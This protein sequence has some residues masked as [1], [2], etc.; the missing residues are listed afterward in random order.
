MT[1][2]RA[3]RTTERVRTAGVFTMLITVL[4]AARV[5][6]QPPTVPADAVSLREA[7]ARA[8][9]REPSIRAARTEIDVALGHLSQAGLKPN[10]M[11][12]VGRQEQPGG[13][14]KQTTLS[15]EWPLDLFRVAGR[16]SVAEREID[17]VRLRVAD[18]ERLLVAEV[19]AAYGAAAAAQ[20]ER[21]V[22]SE[23][24]ETATGQLDVV[25]G[26]VEAGATPPLDR[27]LLAVETRRLDADRLLQGARVD[28]SRIALQ[29][30]LGLSPTE[31]LTL[32]DTLDAL[33]DV[34]GVFS[35]AGNSLTVGRPL[36]GQAEVRADVQAAASDVRVAEASIDRAR[37]DGR[38]DVSLFGTYT[39]MQT[40]FP[41]QGFGPDGRLQPVGD[42][43]HY[44]AVGATLT[45]P[46]RNDNRGEIAASVA[47]RRGA[48]ARYAAADL[49]ART[50]VAAAFTL[51]QQ[52][53]AAVALYA[54]EI[55]PLARHNVDVVR[56]TYLLGRGTVAD[57]LSE[58][59][60]YLEIER[61]YTDTLKQAY[62]ARTSL[63]SALGVQP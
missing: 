46:W 59:R 49:Q 21:D 2:P 55:R 34:N 36:D 47:R 25:R 43:F 41:Q 61:A 37:R 10:P 17:A 40:A 33:V 22:L 62:D 26:R 45:V 38:F 7:I 11:L 9:E 51:D 32:R 42:A 28:H 60:R 20:R 13:T 16:V 44:L 56:Q 3:M 1:K 35:S 18:R 63:L 30:L 24:A 50:E 19:R 27:D 57:V 48:E 8:M 14:D 54:G 23:L 4:V 15:V 5:Q 52:T 31:R 6:G 53:R 12:S 39:R 29:R 58:Q